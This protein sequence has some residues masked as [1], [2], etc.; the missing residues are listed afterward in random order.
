MTSSQMATC[1][2]AQWT[3]NSKNQS[4]CV[5]ASALAG[6]CV[7]G[8]FTLTPLEP[9]FVYLGP[10]QAAATPC[11]CSSVYYSLLSA[12]GTCQNRNYISFPRDLPQ[13]VAVPHWAYQNVT[14]NDGW[15]LADAQADTG[16]EVTAAPASST[17]ASGSGSATGSNSPQ[18][19]NGPAGPT[20]KSSNTGAIAGGVVGGI[21]GLALIGALI[22]FF[23]RRRR[24]QKVPASAQYTAAPMMSPPPMMQAN[25][26]TPLGYGDGSS[27]YQHTGGSGGMP[28]PQVYNPDNPS[29]FPT[30]EFAPPGGLNYSG[31]SPS[32][33]YSQQNFGQQAN[34]IPPAITGQSSNSGYTQA[35]TSLTHNTNTPRYTGVPEL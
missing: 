5:V 13:G 8:D 33:N 29:T 28:A 30:N 31:G 15:V 1:S 32:P 2:T 17:S 26:P 6:V 9:D 27:H 34:Y 35:N 24:Q 21:V 4:P 18:N 12:C 25:T 20:R 23:L 7:G 11:R 10:S 22:F 19:T 14:V 3:F 16:A